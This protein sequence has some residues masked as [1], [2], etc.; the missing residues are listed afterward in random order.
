[1]THYQIQR[2][3]APAPLNFR[4]RGSRWRDMFESMKP[5]EWFSL[6]EDDKVKTGAAA[7]SYLKGRYSL[8]RIEDGTYCF[9]KL[10]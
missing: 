6:P 10:R 4:G 8:Y 1:M 5:G 3:P 2:N 9:V 7:A